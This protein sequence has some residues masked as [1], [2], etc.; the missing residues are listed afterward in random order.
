MTRLSAMRTVRALRRRDAQSRARRSRILQ[1]ARDEIAIERRERLRLGRFARR[2]AQNELPPADVAPIAELVADLAIDPDRSEPERFVQTDAR[3][4][5]KADAGE[6]IDV[7]LRAQQREEPLVE[8]A[9]DAA[10]LRR[11]I[12]I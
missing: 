10:S 7:A 5:R 1:N 8:R 4:I 11:W 2:L 6:R 9:S 3:G 12:E